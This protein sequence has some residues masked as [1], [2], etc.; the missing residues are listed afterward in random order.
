MFQLISMSNATMPCND[1]GK[2]MTKKALN[3]I[4]PKQAESVGAA[5]VP[6]GASSGEFVTKMFEYDSGRQVTVYVPLKEA[7]GDRFRR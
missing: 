4:N 7:R 5:A 1:K 6:S 3:S 2:V